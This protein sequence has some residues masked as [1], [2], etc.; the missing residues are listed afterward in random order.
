FSNDNWYSIHTLWDIGTYFYSLFVY[1]PL[2]ELRGLKATGKTKIMSISRQFTF[3][4]TEEM[5][6]PSE[7]TLFRITHEQRPT[8]YVDEAEK[9]YTVYKGKVEADPRAELINSGYKY[10]GTVPRQEKMGNKYLTIY[11]KTYSPTMI[12]SI[13]GLYGATEDRAIVHVTVKPLGKDKRGS[14]E[15]ND[16]NGKWQ[17][18]RDELYLFSLQNWKL[19]KAKYDDFQLKTKLTNRDLW[20][21]KPLFVLANMVEPKLF[22]EIKT[23]A[24][25]LN[26]IKKN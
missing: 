6:N 16:K 10:T 8:K 15:P 25:S 23:F 2:F 24:E 22:E 13:N 12:G 17:E 4:A 19:I 1:Y 26:D 21:W 5:T 9:L 14:I 11:Y 20:L 7:A 3:N 18:I